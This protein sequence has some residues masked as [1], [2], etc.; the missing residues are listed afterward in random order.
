MG[1]PE[2]ERHLNRLHLPVPE[3]PLGQL[4]PVLARFGVR[5]SIVEP[6]PVQTEF[7]ATREAQRSRGAPSGEDPNKPLLDAYMTALAGRMSAAQTGDDVAKV[8]LEAATAEAPHLRY[9]T[10]DFAR[11]IAA[12]VRVD[13]SGD[14]M[15]KQ[16]S[17]QIGG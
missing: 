2:Q 1:E 14:S 6:G 5:V 12:L 15:L 11:D 8:L 9:Q 10:S 4:A 7:L 17:A 16:T 3:V 13:P